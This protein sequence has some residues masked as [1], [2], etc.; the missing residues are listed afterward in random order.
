M[1]TRLSAVSIAL[2]ASLI[3]ASA[4]WA[5]MGD[6]RMISASDLKWEDVP[7]LPPG[8]KI[9]VIEG[10]MTDAVPFTIR[11]K[12]PANYRIPAHSHPGVERVTVLSGTFHMGTGD[13]LDM[14]KSMALSPGDMMIMQPKTD[15]FAWTK[16]E[17][18]V[19]LNGMGPWG[20]TYV[21]PADDPRRGACRARSTASSRRG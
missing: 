14:Q 5:Q 2:A 4:G 21:N 10:P 15:H 3:A 17:V 18:I 12:F 8:G 7:S 20:V 13:T 6:H 19:Q 16:D 1:S 9:A 11:L